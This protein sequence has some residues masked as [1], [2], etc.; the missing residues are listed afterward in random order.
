MPLTSHD[1]RILQ[2]ASRD[3]Q[4]RLTFCITEEGAIALLG[5]GEPQP[6]SAEEALPK[7]EELGLLRRAVGRSYILTPAGWEAVRELV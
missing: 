3:A 1:L 7:L 5:T 2:L 6:V 4:G